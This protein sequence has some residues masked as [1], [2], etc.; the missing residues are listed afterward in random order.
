MRM[1]L[2]LLTGWRGYAA[3]ALIASALSASAAWQLQTWRNE[4]ALAT[5]QRDHAQQ[6]AR[7]AQAAEAAQAA[8]RQEERRR[9][10]AIEE[11]RH[12]ADL[13][14][15]AAVQRERD[16][17]AV[18]LRDALGD[19]AR[20]H[21]PAGS[22]GAAQPGTTAGDPIGVLAELFGELDALAGVYAAQADRARL[23]GL[24]CERAYDMLTVP[25]AGQAA[26]R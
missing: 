14:L 17:A 1:P 19:Y 15:A 12:D 24:T 23:A 9:V 18:R 26:T 7:H 20:R 2:N 13:A 22:A 6:M 10:A 11:I 3:T 4:K 16:A 5:V 25:P 21:R 8:A